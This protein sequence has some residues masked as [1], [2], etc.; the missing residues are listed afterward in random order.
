MKFLGNTKSEMLKKYTEFLNDTYNEL[1]HRPPDKAGLDH[2]ISELANKKITM[3]GVRKEILESEER[4]LV[5]AEEKLALAEEKYKKPLEELYDEL[6]RRPPDKAGLDHYIGLLA[7][8]KITMEGVRKEILESE[9]GRNVQSFSHYSAKYWNDLKEVQRYKNRLATGDESTEI[10]QTKKSYTLLCNICGSKKGFINSH[11][12]ALREGLSCKN[13]GSTSRDRGYIW[14]LGYAM[15]LENMP[16]CDWPINKSIK[17]L[18]TSGYRSYPKYLTEKFDY[19]NPK[20]SDDPKLLD[21]NPK[22]FADVENLQ[23]EKDFFDYVISSDVFEHVRRDNVA[24]ENI[25]NVLKPGGL[26]VL[27]A[28]LVL[29]LPENQNRIKI[30]ETQEQDVPLLSKF[31]HS[32]NSLVY[33]VYGLEILQ[34][35]NQFGFFSVIINLQQPEF[36]ISTQEVVLSRKNNP[37][38]LDRLYGDTNVS[39][40]KNIAQGNAISEELLKKYTEILNDAYNE[41]LHRPPD[42]AGLDHYI[43]ELANDTITIEDVIKEILESEEGRNVQSFSHYSA[44]YWNDL[45]E[46]QEYKNRLATGDESKDWIDDI[47][48]RFN[49]YLPFEDVL[50]VGCGNGWLERRLYDLG[51]GL[52]FDAFDISEKYLKIARQEKH[53][54]KINYFVSD[55]NSMENI[56]EKKYDAVFNYA[57]LHHADNLE[58]AVK[59]LAKVLKP[60]GLMFNEEYVGPSRNQYSDQ[61]LTIMRNTM[62]QL[63]PRFRSTYPLRPSLTNFRVEPTEAVHSDLIRSTFKKYFDTIYERNLNGGVAYQILWNNIDPFKDKSDIEAQDTLKHLLEIDYEL[64]ASNQVPILFWY[65]VGKPRKI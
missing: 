50:I 36:N 39:M 20:F 49:T 18:E 60:N 65:S 29:G 15:K 59:K 32:D 19:Y 26:F 7:N 41:L 13:C 57:I 5:L 22:E 44:K 9:E 37:I 12:G 4:K 42:K 56:E 33:R 25:Y 30:G 17:I 58:A 64:S 31:Y 14:T 55:I 43:S 27:T 53:N 47:S 38:Q 3:E 52:H 10:C 61:H 46:V 28:P 21:E 16:L 11:H 51:I 62:L 2:Y 34:Q 8:E 1:L 40:I 45:K 63:P 54:R 23:Y 48:Y 6:L 24:F 35:L